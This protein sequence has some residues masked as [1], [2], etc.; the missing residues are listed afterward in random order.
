MIHQ[1]DHTFYHKEGP[2]FKSQAPHE[3]TMDAWHLRK[4]HE[5]WSKALVSPPSLSLSPSKVGRGESA[6]SSGIMQARSPSDNCGVKSKIKG[7]EY[8]FAVITLIKNL[9][10]FQQDYTSGRR[11][12]TTLPQPYRRRPRYREVTRTIVMRKQ[13]QSNLF[14]EAI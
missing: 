2:G 11:L 6:R 10:K 7:L 9:H 14:F 13:N 1:V 4:L 5:Q 8:G 3:S 12:G